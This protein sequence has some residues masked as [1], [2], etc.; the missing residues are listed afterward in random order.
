[1]VPLGSTEQHAYLSLMVDTLIPE[2]LAQEAAEPLGIPVFPGGALRD[3]PLLLRLSRDGVLRGETYRVPYQGFLDSLSGSGFRRIVF[4]NGHGGNAPG[5]S[6]A[7]EWM[8]DHPGPQGEDLQ[9]VDCSEDPG[10]DQ[11]GRPGRS[12]A[13]WM[14]NFPWTRLEGVGL[15]EGQKAPFDMARRPFWIQVIQGGPGGRELRRALPETRRGDDGH[16][17][18]DGGGGQG[19]HGGGWA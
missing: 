11:G 8:A 16:L 19:G 9:L 2:K 17:G 13:S 7:S 15:P 5:A 10:E 18:G 1:M 6:L 12:H 4:V 3:L 14:E